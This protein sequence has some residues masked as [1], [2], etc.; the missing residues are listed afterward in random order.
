MVLLLSFIWWGQHL[1]APSSW[2]W[3]YTFPGSFRGL[4]SNNAT[5]AWWNIHWFPV[6]PILNLICFQLFL[7]V[8]FYGLSVL[9]FLRNIDVIAFKCWCTRCGCCLGFLWVCALFLF[10]LSKCSFRILHMYLGASYAFFLIKFDLITDKQTESSSS[11]Y[12]FLFLFQ[13]LIYTKS[14]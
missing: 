11:N 10:S 6:D 4:P 5:L 2:C 3:T 8:L 12:L 13:L 7:T 9:L 1:N 14:N